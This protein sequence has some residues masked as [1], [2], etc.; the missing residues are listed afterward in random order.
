MPVKVQSRGAL[1]ATFA[2]RPSFTLDPLLHGGAYYVQ[3]AS[4]MFLW[5]VFEQPLEKNTQD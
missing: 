2:E 4:S 5:Y 3:E 1:M